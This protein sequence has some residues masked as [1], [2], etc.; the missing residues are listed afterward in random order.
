M[1]EVAMTIGIVAAFLVI[2]PLFW[3]GIVLLV[4]RVSGCG[5]PFSSYSGCL[6]VTV[7]TD[8]FHLKPIF[9]FAAGHDP[10]FMPWSAVEMV[11]SSGTS[12]FASA[13]FTIRNKDDGAS[14]GLTRY[15]RKLIDSLKKHFQFR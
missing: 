8:G 9:V 4:S 14:K 5:R 3:M 1:K 15:G 6:T 7:S 2:F 10:I 13:H 12:F 11:R